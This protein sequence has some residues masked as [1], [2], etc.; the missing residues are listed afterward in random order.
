MSD[1]WTIGELAE[2]AAD[3]LGPATRRPNGRVRDVP[4]ERLIRWY[5]TIG[6]LDPPLT[7]RGRVALYG[8][9]HL[10]QLLAVKRRQA[11]GRSIAEIQAEL[12][13]AT[14]GTLETIARPAVPL[15]PPVDM[16]HPA[17]SPQSPPDP[18]APKYVPTSPPPARARFW[19]ERPAPPS[20]PAQGPHADDADEGFTTGLTDGAGVGP[21]DRL[22][23]DL[24]GG[25]SHPPDHGLSDRL[26]HG[27]R[28]APGVTLLLDGPAPGPAEVAAL[29][30]AARPLL[31]ALAARRR[32][33]APPRSAAPS[34]APD[35][36]TAGAEAGAE[37]AHPGPVR[38]GPGPSE[39]M[40]A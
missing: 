35:D 33:P 30:E 18:R 16:P 9:R 24:G 15:A 23:D 32:S 4:N 34:P 38:P 19:A 11:E 28:L 26:V 1:T 29:R 8:R 2:R 17:P 39:G 10:L 14:D 22:T 6:L 37:T 20:A 3:L 12:A 27:V 5:T 40:H 7:R 21:A 13:G 36:I 25:V 31:A